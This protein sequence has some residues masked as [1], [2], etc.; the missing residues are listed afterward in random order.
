MFDEMYQFLY[1]PL[2]RYAVCNCKVTRFVPK[3]NAHQVRWGMEI[4]AEWICKTYA[5]DMQE[6]HLC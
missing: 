4:R 6:V 1:T 3:L 5:W 2:L